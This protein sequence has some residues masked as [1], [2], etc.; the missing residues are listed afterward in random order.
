M[1]TQ[2][3]IVQ[4]L[5][6]ILKTNILAGE[7]VNDLLE[8]L[9]FIHAK[10]YLKDGITETEWKECYIPITPENILKELRDY[11]PFAFTKAEDQRGIS[12]ERSIMHMQNWLWLLEDQPLYDFACNEE[13]YPDYGMPILV[14]IKEKYGEK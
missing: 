2:E 9:E 1:R 4:R 5:D 7:V 13:N 8:H 12:A 3:Q 14:K 10:K 6:R 11:L